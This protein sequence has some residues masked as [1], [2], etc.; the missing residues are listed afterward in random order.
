M[1]A[2]EV[3]MCDKAAYRGV[4]GYPAGEVRCPY[5]GRWNV[6]EEGQTSMDCVVCG[7]TYRRARGKKQ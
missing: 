1:D 5:C 2:G 7:K 6:F 4:S 3:R